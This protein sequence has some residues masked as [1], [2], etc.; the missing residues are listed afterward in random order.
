M[1]FFSQI[2]RFGFLAALIAGFSLFS[3]VVRTFDIGTLPVLSE[4]LQYYTSL[5]AW[6]FGWT[7]FIGLTTPDWYTNCF[8]LSAVGGGIVM[9]AIII[10][11][12]EH[13]AQ[14]PDEPLD[15][16]IVTGVKI[17]FP[18]IFAF[19]LLGIL[20]WIMAATSFVDP[21]HVRAVFAHDE[22]KTYTLKEPLMRFSQNTPKLIR[23]ETLVAIGSFLLLFGFNAYGLSAET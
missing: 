5:G 14:D 7:K 23:W 8:V 3:L 2:A 12:L 21:L 11:S 19:T 6:A 15:N 4:M 9:R 10:P 1:K 22:N 16:Q 17:M 13:Q 18:I 20:G